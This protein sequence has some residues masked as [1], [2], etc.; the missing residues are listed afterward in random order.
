M[1]SFDPDEIQ[2]RCERHGQLHPL[3][4]ARRKIRLQGNA[5]SLR[6]CRVEPCR[7]GLQ[8]SAAAP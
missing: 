1:M 3:A 7:R 6:Y 2:D 4:D 8:F 5:T